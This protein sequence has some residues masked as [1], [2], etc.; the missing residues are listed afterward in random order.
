MDKEELSIL[1][2]AKAGDQV[3]LAALIVKYD[4]AMNKIAS[5]FQNRFKNTYS[6][7]FLE[8]KQDALIAF[9]K[10]VS[11][12]DN[13]KNKSFL[14]YSK[15]CMLNA[16]T[17]TIRRKRTETPSPTIPIEPGEDNP[18][19]NVVSLRPSPQETLE[20]EKIAEEIR[21]ALKKL[22]SESQYCV[23][24]LYFNGF[25]YLEIASLLHISKKTVDNTIAGAKIKI[26]KNKELFAPIIDLSKK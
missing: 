17:S 8:L 1:K 5:F 18:G 14:N 23:I 15:I 3:S 2:K 10:S 20:N 4:P 12:Y 21:A 9:L 11:R 24:E 6:L 22:L 19:I 16:L 7:D 25:S 13:D 26:S